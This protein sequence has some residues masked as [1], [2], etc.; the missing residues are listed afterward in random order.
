[1]A[2]HG[3]FLAGRTLAILD[4]WP[5]PSYRSSI[6]LIEADFRVRPVPLALCLKSTGWDVMARYYPNL[7]SLPPHWHSGGKL[8]RYVAPP[9]GA[10]RR[11][12]VPVSHII[13]L[14]YT[15]G[16]ATRLQT[17]S[18]SQALGRVMTECLAIAHRLTPANVSELVRW[19]SGVDCSA[20]T[21][22]SLDEAVERVAEVAPPPRE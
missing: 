10:A 20:L 12:A 5:V 7:E 13:F 1:M 19:I 17:V 18:R 16:A 21:F 9:A 2:R 14:R 22:S 6:T 3:R 4:C 11:P 8:V 15:E